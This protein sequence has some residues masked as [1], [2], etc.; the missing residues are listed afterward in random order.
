MSLEA[1]LDRIAGSAPAGNPAPPP[2]AEPSPEETPATVPPQETAEKPA[3]GDPPEPEETEV[4]LDAVPE[5][6]G[7]FSKYKPL[8]KDYPELRNILG[9][10]KAFSEI[11]PSFSELRQIVERVPSLEDA[12]QLFSDAENKRILGQTFREDPASFMESLKESDGLAYQ[13]LVT[14]LPEVLAQTDEKLF[15]EQARFYSNRVISNVLGIAHQSGD[16]EL[17]A[18]AQRVAQFLGVRPGQDSA[19]REDNSEAARLRKQLQERDQADQQ[20]AFDT[21]WSETD[22]AIINNCVSL[23]EDTLKRALP[24]ATPAQIERMKKEAWDKTLETLNAQPQTRAQIDSFRSNALQ[25]RMGISEHKQI[26]AYGTG[27]AK[28]VIPKVVKTVIDDWTG[29]VLKLENQKTQKKQAVAERTKD[30]GSGPQATS[31]AAGATVP[32]G[33]PRSMKDVFRELE[34]GTYVRR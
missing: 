3:E 28:L 5:T 21:F 20:A 7:D 11:A 29:N 10:E 31:S 1:V 25:G 19:V 34:S 18:A 15:A 13:Q 14:R 22:G 9:R 8:F 26:V 17:M 4:D 24:Q 33:K 12:E 16:Q 23:I 2:S 27:R 32:N 6:S 30:V